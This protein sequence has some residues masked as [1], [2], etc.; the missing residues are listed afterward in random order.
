M[1][2]IRAYIPLIIL[3]L[4]AVFLVGV[5]D[6]KEKILD[7]TY[8][9]LTKETQHQVECLADNIYHEA[10]YE[11]EDGKVAVA[12]VT[13]NRLQDPRFPKDICGVVKQRTRSTCQFT[14]F[15]EH[16]ITN[17][18]KEVYERA[19]D[20]AVHVYVNYDKIPDITGGALYYHADYVN[21]RWRKLE[22]TTTIGRHIFY[23]ERDGNSI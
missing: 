15:C 4:S 20:I 2:M 11:P 1:R 21:P 14:W 23:K 13:L 19:R 6:A 3:S 10:G 18:T 9:Q 12:L 16:K 17:R 7:I 22:K 8:Y 5:N